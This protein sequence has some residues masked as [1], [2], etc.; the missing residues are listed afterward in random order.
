M[1]PANYKSDEASGVDMI[2]ATSA[3]ILTLLP[4]LASQLSITDRLLESPGRVFDSKRIIGSKQAHPWGVPDSL[5]GVA[6]YGLTLNLAWLA[7][8]RP[9]ARKLLA[10]KLVVDAGAA[11]FNVVRQIVS[12]RKLCSWCTATAV[13]TSFMI[14]A[15]RKLIVEEASALL[16]PLR[17]P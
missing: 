6:S 9:S 1:N 16:Q 4:V 13:C 12:F 17:L 15:G 2:V 7:R 11:G 10:A 8:T 5:L 3:A 14:I